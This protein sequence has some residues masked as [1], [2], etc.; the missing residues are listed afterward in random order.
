M[1]KKNSFY[2]TTA[3]HY[4]NAGPHLGHAYEGL[5]ADIVA[6]YKREKGMPTFFLTG[7][8]EHGDKILRSAK[9]VD[10]GPQAFVDMNAQKFKDLYEA[11]SLSN[12]EFIRTSDQKKHWPGAIALWNTIKETGDI[13]KGVYKGLYCV[14]CEAFKTEKDLVDGKC[15][16]HKIAPEEIEEENYF[17]KLS[18]YADEIIKLIESD[19]IRILPEA[20][21]NEMLA[22]VKEGIEDISFSRPERDIPWGIPVP[23][24][25]GQNMYVWC[26]ALFNYISALGYGTE[27]D[28][29]F[30]KFW[31]ADVHIVGKDI[32]RFHAIFWPA[33]LLSAKLPLP[34]NIWVHGMITSD[35]QK[36]SKSIGN[37]VDPMEY[38]RDYGPDAFRYFLA[39]EIPPFEDG[40]FSE[41][42]FVTAYNANLANGLGNLVSRTI[43]M[44]QTYFGGTIKK[45]EEYV[46]VPLLIRR[47]LFKG[48]E[49]LQGYS[50]PYTIEWAILP[51]YQEKMEAFEVQQAADVIW[52]FIGLLDGY[53]TKHEPFKLIKED[54]EKTE[55]IL[56]NILYGLYFVGVMVVPFMPDTA[57]KIWTAIGVDNMD[58][59]YGTPLSFQ[60][61]QIDEALFARIELKKI[62][63]PQP[64]P[65]PDSQPT[66]EGQV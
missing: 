57:K 31:P 29:N 49:Y 62:E 46:D 21:K 63:E 34:K 44:T 3:I 23:G 7:T 55:N 24:E 11:M 65:Q 15:P 30:K 54:R 19:T 50:I 52:K 58:E 35:G 32:L 39:R 28:E 47:D 37:V 36:M 59:K 25:P 10:M 66:E 53:I 42:K 5:L 14:G 61:Q 22:L 64:V 12:D 45:K 40:D 41:E 17:F 43:K 6:R 26:D 27:H 51:E 18:K 13:Y 48:T 60:T 16:D 38:I 56:W 4:A 8:D 33:M 20:R 1:E 9:K 2:I